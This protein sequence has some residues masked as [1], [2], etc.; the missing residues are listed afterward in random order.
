MNRRT[1][2]RGALTIL[3]G[4]V[5]APVKAIEKLAKQP[6]KPKKTWSIPAYNEMQE[7]FPIIRAHYPNMLAADIVCVQPMTRKA[8]EVFYV[9]FGWWSRLKQW[10]RTAA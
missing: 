6:L 8:G 9:N 7:L 4:A 1:F 2:L 5:V 10:W 3:T